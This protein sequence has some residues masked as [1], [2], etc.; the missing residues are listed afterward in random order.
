M[1]KRNRVLWILLGTGAVGLALT[2][3]IAIGT[4]EIGSKDAAKTYAA[5]GPV[6]AVELAVHEAQ[7]RVIE[8]TGASSVS[9]SAKAW[10][11]GEM[12]LDAMVEVELENGVLKITETP[13]P[14]EFFGVFPQPYELHLTLHVPP[15]TAP[16][17][18][19]GQ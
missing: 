1:K 14:R 3:G 15:G 7:V 19:E 6:E 11:T 12:D 9:A 8:T 13:L 2:A 10:L 18:E 16:D 5:G 17:L 4:G